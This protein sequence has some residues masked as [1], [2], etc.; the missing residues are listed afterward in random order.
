MKQK[1]K[2]LNEK[3]AKLSNEEAED[4]DSDKAPEAEKDYD[5]LNRDFYLIGGIHGYNLMQYIIF[6]YY[7][8]V[9]LTL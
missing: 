9:G 7:R 4:M 1:I 3:V 8:P 2:T 6:F 5:E